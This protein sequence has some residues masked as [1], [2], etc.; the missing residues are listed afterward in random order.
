LD[1][2]YFDQNRTDRTN[3]IA[4]PFGTNYSVFWNMGWPTSADWD[5]TAAAWT[6]EL[7]TPDSAQLN[8]LTLDTTE[9]KVKK[10]DRVLYYNIISDGSDPSAIY[11]MSNGYSGYSGY[12]GFSKHVGFPCV[13]T[14]VVPDIG[15]NKKTVFHTMREVNEP[16]VCQLSYNRFL[17]TWWSN[18]YKEYDVE[19]D[20]YTD[21]LTKMIRTSNTT[22]PVGEYT[23]AMLSSFIDFR[24]TNIKL[25][26]PTQTQAYDFYNIFYPVF[27]KPA[28]INTLTVTNEDAGG[29]GVSVV[30]ATADGANGVVPVKGIVLK[31]D[32]SASPNFS[33]VTG[34]PNNV[35]YFK[36]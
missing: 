29:A 34:N 16:S 1:T 6:I 32:V 19:K 26:P 18:F 5:P 23:K 27:T 11:Q 4:I 9:T 24:M 25:K 3:S 12:P 33:Q 13:Y 22:R 2:L 17:M 28:V 36:L 35:S 8:I 31:A 7:I 20:G 21:D 14:I 10:N 30:Q 15:D